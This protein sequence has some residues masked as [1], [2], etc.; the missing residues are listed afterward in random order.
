MLQ[1]RNWAK[2][3]RGPIAALVAALLAVAVVIATS[4]PAQAAKC[5]PPPYPQ[6][7]FFRPDNGAP[8]SDLIV[9]GCSG[10]YA[11]DLTA[12]IAEAR[13]FIAWR[14]GAVARPAIVL[15]IDETSLSNWRQML[16]NDFQYIATG[17][18]LIDR[19]GPCSQRAWELRAQADPIRPMVDLFDAARARGVA[20]FFITG[21]R[22]DPAARAATVR[23]LLRAGYRGWSALVM[24]APDERKLSARDYKTQRRAQ[25]AS[26][27][28]TIVASIGDQ[29]SDLDGGYADRRFKLPNPFYFIP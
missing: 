3:G 29:W 16:A 25:I 22:D 1:S 8:K 23:N 26:E 24:R 28:Y 5:P 18:C 17:P 10:R 15:D 27:G 11:S 12:E 13:A 7:G 9:Y 14:A 21:R 6:T 4:P 20:V 2:D 19:G